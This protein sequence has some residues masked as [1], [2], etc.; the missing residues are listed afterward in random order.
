ME[1][2]L[3]AAIRDM[4]AKSVIRVRNYKHVLVLHVLYGFNPYIQLLHIVIKNYS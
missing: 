3:T 1:L 4:K 2:V